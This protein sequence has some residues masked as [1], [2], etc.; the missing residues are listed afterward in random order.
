[1]VLGGTSAA[2]NANLYAEDD[3]AKVS[4]DGH[5]EHCDDRASHKSDDYRPCRHI[6][7][8]G[9]VEGLPQKLAVRREYREPSQEHGQAN[10]YPERKDDSVPFAQESAIERTYAG[11]IASTFLF[12]MSLDSI[13]SGRYRVMLLF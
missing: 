11:H 12:H 13:C 6:S 10:N 4:Q 9:V 7:I 2:P 3:H 8:R 1:M 5:Q